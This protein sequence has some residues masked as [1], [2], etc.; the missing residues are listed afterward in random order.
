MRRESPGLSPIEVVEPTL[1]WQRPDGVTEEVF[2][3][4]GRPIVI[5]RAETNAIVVDSPFVSKAHASVACT[6]GQYFVEDLQSANGTR[7][8]GAPIATSVLAPG[9]VIEIGDHQFTFV[10]R[11]ADGPA[12]RSGGSTPGGGAMKF[13]RLGMAAGVTAMV[14]IVVLRMLMPTGSAPRAAPPDDVPPAP[15]AAAD[16]SALAR[17]VTSDS[18]RVV[19]VV[20]AAQLAG[21]DPADALF[22]DAQIQMRSARYFDAARL[23]AATLKARPDHPTAKARLDDALA[24]LH[25]AATQLMAEA[26]RQSSQLRWPEAIVTWEQVIAALPPGDPRVAQAKAGVAHA[27]TR[28]GR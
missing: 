1:V 22:D 11:A 25:R 13:I 8:N 6:G 18:P 23:F 26:D 14:L 19:E 17:H 3:P 9:D 20:N 5:G 12:R 28:V 10:D 24:E 21:V 16:I 4:L 2:V 27:R 7:L 15:V